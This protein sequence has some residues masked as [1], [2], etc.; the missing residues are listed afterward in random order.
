VKHLLATVR[1]QYVC[2]A[3]DVGAVAVLRATGDV[4]AAAAAIIVVVIVVVVVYGAAE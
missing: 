3:C 2:V 4:V 1:C